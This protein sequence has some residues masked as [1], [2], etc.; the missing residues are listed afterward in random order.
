MELSLCEPEHIATSSEGQ[1]TVMKYN[2]DHKYGNMGDLE[3]PCSLTS[4]SLVYVR[5]PLIVLTQN[6]ASLLS[7]L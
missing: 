2:S 6:V 7:L 3:S 5:K 1:H 4:L